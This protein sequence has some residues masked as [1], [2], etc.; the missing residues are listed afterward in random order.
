MRRVVAIFMIVTCLAPARGAALSASSCVQPDGVSAFAT[1]S[2]HAVLVGTLDG[3][4]YR[5]LDGDHCFI[6]LGSPPLHVAIGVVLVPPGHPAWILAG[7]ANN[8]TQWGV[9]STGSGLYLSRDDGKTWAASDAGL[10]RQAFLPA[11]LIALPDGAL[12]LTY[13]CSAYSSFTCGGIARSADGGRTWLPVGPRGWVG[14]PIVSL[15]PRDVLALIMSD[16]AARMSARVVRSLDGGRTWRAAPGLPGLPGDVALLFS[17]PW[18]PSIVLAGYGPATQVAK[19]ARTTD[20]GRHWSFTR[21][22]SQPTF[23]GEPIG[24]FAAI[25]HPRVLLLSVGSV[26]R[27]KDDGATWTLSTAGLPSIDRAQIDALYAAPD[28]ATAYA[29]NDNLYEYNGVVHVLKGEPGL[30]RSTDGGVTWRPNA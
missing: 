21:G 2:N 22:R 23:V 9:Q 14:G 15:G 13:V 1:G 5:S 19:V 6:A 27:S 8:V 12:L 10:G 16:D 29:G 3:R 18:D 7:T 28:G 11:Q 25:A 26:Y 24:A 20:G 17:P 30:Y 4:L